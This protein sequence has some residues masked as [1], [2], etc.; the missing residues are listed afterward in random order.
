[1][2]DSLSNVFFSL[3][4]C[5]FV[6]VW[7]DAQSTATPLPIC[8]VFIL[9]KGHALDPYGVRCKTSGKLIE[10][11]YDF[12]LPRGDVKLTAPYK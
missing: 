8:V 3:F 4:L 10:H 12:T 11:F 1:M 7:L 9:Q 6:I 5:K 2:V